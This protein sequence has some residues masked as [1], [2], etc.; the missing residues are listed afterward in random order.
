MISIMALCG[1]TNLKGG[2]EGLIPESEIQD[3]QELLLG[4]RKSRSRCNSNFSRD[5]Y[6]H[7]DEMTGTGAVMRCFGIVSTV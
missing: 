6:G 3:L 4:R 2:R 1:I 5:Y 7:C